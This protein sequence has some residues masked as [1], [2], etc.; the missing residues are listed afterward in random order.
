MYASWTV[1][2]PAR[3]LTADGSP[4]DATVRFQLRLLLGVSGIACAWLPRVSGFVRVDSDKL[5]NV[6]IEA[7]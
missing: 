5:S 3:A 6:L 2:P 7:Q 4:M 1:S